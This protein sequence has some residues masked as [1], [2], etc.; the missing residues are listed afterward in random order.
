MEKLKEMFIQSSE[1]VMILNKNGDIVWHN[2]SLQ[3]MFNTD[4]ILQ[5][6]APELIA[7][8]NIGKVK[9]PPDTK[10]A[11]KRMILGELV[12]YIITPIPQTD[13][14][15]VSLRHCEKEDLRQI[16]HDIKSRLNSILGLA[17]LVRDNLINNIYE[18]INIDLLESSLRSG[19]QLS[20]QLNRFLAVSRLSE[21]IDIPK[22][23]KINL[24]SFLKEI[25]ISFDAE[26]S[27]HNL[28]L[29]LKPL[30]KNLDLAINADKALLLI[31]MENA[32]RNAAEEI[33]DKQFT[34]TKKRQIIITFGRYSSGTILQISN[35][36]E[37]LENDFQ[38]IFKCKF[39]TKH[40]GN[41]LG[42][43]AIR[44]IVEAH[45]GTINTTLKN[46]IISIKLV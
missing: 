12:S 18:P 8:E 25:K 9:W 27:K 37:L 23:E 1:A 20:N 13:H 35:Y 40:N 31:A 7:Q 43:N 22:K 24:M 26:F 2:N 17:D 4:Q 38:K 15:F 19:Y 46:G 14:Y 21:G 28:T 41:G 5:L 10:R 44:L 11:I 39:S 30:D 29:L 6:N 16:N 3:K 34:E 33:I 42:T 45:G 32:L 36:C